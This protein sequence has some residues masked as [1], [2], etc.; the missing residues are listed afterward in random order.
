MII[1]AADV[2]RLCVVVIGK[3]E[4]NE[5]VQDLQKEGEAG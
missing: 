1:V 4:E 5:R 3:E 2:R